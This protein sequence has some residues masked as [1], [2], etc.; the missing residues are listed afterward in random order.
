VIGGQFPAWRRVSELSDEII[1]ALS[2]SNMLMGY[3]EYAV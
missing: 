1:D 2:T 3:M